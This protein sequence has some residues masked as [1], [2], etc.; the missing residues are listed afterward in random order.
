MNSGKRSTGGILVAALLIMLVPGPLSAEETGISEPISRP[1]LGGPNA[2]ENQIESDQAEKDVLFDSDFFKP[3]SEWKGNVS[4][5]TG[6]SFGTDYT[7]VFLG[8]DDSLA[9]ADDHASGGMIRLYGNWELTGRGTDNTG[10]LNFKVDHRHSY[11][12]TAPASF[13]LDNLGHVDSI[14]STFSDQGWRLT[15]LHWRQA[16]NRGAV[17]ALAGFIS[18]PDFVDTFGLGSPWLHF[19][20]LAFTTGAGAMTL[21]GDG[22]LG[23]IVGGW[24]SKNLYITGGFV[25]ANSLPDDP[26][27][28]FDT[29]FNDREFFKHIEIGWTTSSE[30][31]YLDNL[32]LTLWHVDER[33]DAG[34]ED[35]RGGV[36]SYTKYINDRWMPFIRVAVG[37][38]G[39]GLLERSVSTGLSYQ[40]NPIGAAA[41]NLLGFGANW[42]Q[43]NEAIF[44]SGL[45][46]QYTFEFFYRLQVT[47]ELAITPNIELLIDPALNPDADSIWA[48]GLRARLAL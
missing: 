36:L 24:L 8:A 13:A 27:E 28:G 40:P 5:Q 32:H 37:K 47:Q 29:F 7:A 23:A 3:Y 9:G 11:S 2:V 26:L 18:V 38:G 33:K 22:A 45:D 19:M 16:W 41:G 25:D 4:E 1:Q 20:D 14:A 42:G 6:F 21:P 46:D 34:V 30:R 44:G 35:G 12:A 15:N 48:F 31:A 39:N 17:F 43:P 10:A